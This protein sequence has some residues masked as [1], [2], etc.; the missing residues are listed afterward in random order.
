MYSVINVTYLSFITFLVCLKENVSEFLD[1]KKEGNL[2]VNGKIGNVA[3]L[4]K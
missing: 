4:N 3:T 1:E 2:M